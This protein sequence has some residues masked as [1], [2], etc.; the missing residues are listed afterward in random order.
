MSEDESAK[1]VDFYAHCPTC[2]YE[3]SL[4]TQRPCNYCLSIPMNDGT[5]KPIKWKKKDTQ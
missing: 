1:E 2:F 5:D 3:S 4:E